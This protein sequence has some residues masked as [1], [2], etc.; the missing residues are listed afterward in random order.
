M[1]KATLRRRSGVWL[2]GIVTLLT[3]GAHRDGPGAGR[4]KSLSTDA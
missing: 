4:E 1:A 2:A 3:A